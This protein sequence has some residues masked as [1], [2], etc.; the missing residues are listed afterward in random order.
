MQIQ[1][2]E[3]CLSLSRQTWQNGRTVTYVEILHPGDRYQ[4]AGTFR[5][6]GVQ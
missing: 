4:F 6:S 5:P 2:S 3:P 1:R